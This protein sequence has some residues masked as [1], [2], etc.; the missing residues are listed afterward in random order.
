[1]AEAEEE[2]RNLEREL[3]QQ[4]QHQQ[5]NSEVLYPH[6][7][8]L[9]VIFS[10]PSDIYQSSTTTI[11]IHLKLLWS[12]FSLLSSHKLKKS[13][14]PQHKRDLLKEKFAKESEEMSVKLRES[15]QRLQQQGEEIA[16]V[17]ECVE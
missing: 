1:M 3:Q 14:L 8:I 4:L 17:S 15:Q 13:T 9:S 12:T 7:K 16:T 2:Y 5:K 10:L 11:Y 6:C